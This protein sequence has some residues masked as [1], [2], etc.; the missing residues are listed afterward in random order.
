L[1]V[2]GGRFFSFLM[3]PAR[4]EAHG[5]SRFGRGTRGNAL[6]VPNV[7]PA[8]GGGGKQF[9]LDAGA[10]KCVHNA[11]IG[12]QCAEATTGGLER[13]EERDEPGAVERAEIVTDKSV[14]RREDAFTVLDGSAIAPGRAR[15]N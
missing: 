15:A 13:L 11:G 4:R 10:E 14:K 9:G 6:G 12:V 1:S 8:S 2:R 5:S 3:P 7:N